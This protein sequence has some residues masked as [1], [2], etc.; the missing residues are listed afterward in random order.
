VSYRQT[1]AP[2]ADRSILADARDAPRDIRRVSCG[3]WPL[4]H[5]QIGPGLTSDSCCSVRGTPAHH[6]LATAVRTSRKPPSTRIRARTRRTAT[7]CSNALPPVALAVLGTLRVFEPEPRGPLTRRE[8]AKIQ[9]PTFVD[10]GDADDA[11]QT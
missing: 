8:G 2:P 4:T 9:C 10:G 1:R 5:A 6:T 11:G 7:L 3:H